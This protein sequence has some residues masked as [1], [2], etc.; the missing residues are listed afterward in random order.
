MEWLFL[1]RRR[2][3]GRSLESFFSRKARSS[4]YS[5]GNEIERGERGG[6]EE[7]R[8]RGFQFPLQIQGRKKHEK[9]ER[10]RTVR[11]QKRGNLRIA[12]QILCF[13]ADRIKNRWKFQAWSSW[14]FARKGL[15]REGKKKNVCCIINRALVGGGA[16]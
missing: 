3:R 6:G 1:S 12:R 7:E 10:F 13:Q 2:K 15:F 4:C 8:R 11:W 14:E 5:M 16:I 9:M